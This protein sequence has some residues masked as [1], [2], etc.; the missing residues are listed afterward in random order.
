MCV[1]IYRVICL[2]CGTVSLREELQ[3]RF[4]ALNPE[5]RAQ[6]LGVAPDGDVFL[7]DEQVLH[8]RVPSCTACSGTLK[9]EVT[10]F[11][12]NVSKATVQLVHDRLAESDAMLVT[13]S[14]LQVSFQNNIY[15]LNILFFR[16][17]MVFSPFCFPGLFWIPV[18][19]GSK[20]EVHSD[21][22][23]EHWADAGGP[24]GRA[25]SQ[26]SLWRGA[27][28]SA[29]SLTHDPNMDSNL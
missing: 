14:S 2:G 5:W 21:R 4:E 22:H 26:R 11:G 25:Q 19:A 17:L 16:R 13:G 7:E 1:C 24:L 29:A 28:N 27:V 20:G 8:F 6:T 10:F 9:P 12:D 18:L 3:R 23:P 15:L